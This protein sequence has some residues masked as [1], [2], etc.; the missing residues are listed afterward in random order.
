MR[1]CVSG[2]WGIENGMHGVRDGAIREDA[3]RIRKGSASQ[4]V[5]IPRNITILL[6]KRLGHESEAAA[7]RPYVY[8]PEESLEALSMS[9]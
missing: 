3:S 7:T 6:F 5:A 9:V 2:H 1:A 8:K 4:V